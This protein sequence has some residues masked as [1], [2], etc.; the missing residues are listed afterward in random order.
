MNLKT[1]RQSKN[2]PTRLAACS[3]GVTVRTIN[4]YECGKRMPTPDKLKKLAHLYGCTVDD[5]ID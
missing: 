5:L 2:I 4:H 3:L 1:V